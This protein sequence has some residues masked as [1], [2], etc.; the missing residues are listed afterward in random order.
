MRRWCREETAADFHFVLSSQ[1]H[2]LCERAKELES[3]RTLTAKLQ[4]D[5]AELRTTIRK[6]LSSR[7]VHVPN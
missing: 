3:H 6:V 5:C 1:A 7:D 4:E 2:N